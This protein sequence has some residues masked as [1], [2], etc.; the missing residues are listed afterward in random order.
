MKIKKI[1][2]LSKEALEA[3][4]V[5]TD[6]ES[7]IIC[8]AHP[9]NYKIDSNLEGPIYC[10]DVAELVKVDKK[11]F[12]IEKLDGHFEYR[13]TGQLIDKQLETVKVGQFLL[14]LDTDWPGDIKD[15]DFVSFIS[16]RLDIM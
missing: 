10:F 1:D 7:E 11:S 5:V 9:L 16:K 3:E 13:F 14:E 6:G 2:W 15:G 8:F 4:V 12:I